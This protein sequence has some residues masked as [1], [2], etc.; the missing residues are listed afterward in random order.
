MAQYAVLNH[1]DVAIAG[2]GQRA[3][4]KGW[5]PRMKLVCFLATGSACWAVVLAPFFLFG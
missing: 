3:N 1:P 2:T 5:S 4:T